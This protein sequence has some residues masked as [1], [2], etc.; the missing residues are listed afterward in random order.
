MSEE[1]T[2]SVPRQTIH[3]VKAEY[4]PGTGIL[5]ASVKVTYSVQSNK[6]I[7]KD[8]EGKVLFEATRPTTTFKFE[9]ILKDAVVDLLT[10]QPILIQSQNKARNKA[11]EDILK[12]LDGKTLD[13]APTVRIAVRT[14]A[15]ILAGVTQDAELMAEMSG[16]EKAALASLLAKM[17]GRK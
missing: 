16:E 12:M 14:P 6:A 13:S 7:G 9:G 8:A 17:A 3:E 2:K 1:T 11:P 4:N 5:K 15:E 10:K